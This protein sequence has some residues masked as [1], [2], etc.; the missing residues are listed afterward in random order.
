MKNMPK[1]IWQVQPDY[2][3]WDAWE[4]LAQ[5][6]KLLYEIMEPIPDVRLLRED[7]TRADY[8]HCGHVNALHG[9]FI[10]VNPASGDPEFKELS[11]KRCR[12]SCEFASLIGADHVVF[13]SSCF[14]FLRGGYL[15]SWSDQCAAFYAQLAEEYRLKICVEN[16]MDVDPV[17]LRRLMEKTKSDSV[18]VCLDIGH[19]HYSRASLEEWFGQLGHWIGYMHLSDNKGSFDEHLTLGTGNVDW[20]S[21]DRLWQQLRGDIPMT[22]EVG[23]VDNVRASLTFLRKYGYFGMGE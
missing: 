3:A 6:E 20:A 10:D 17:P 9:A 13:H 8:L 2:V 16:S 23:S 15:D 1:A 22:L 4:K 11:R 7:G 19:A 14:P 18:C 5:D 12:Q 21:A